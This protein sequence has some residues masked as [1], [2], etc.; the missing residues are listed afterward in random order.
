MPN[1][2]EKTHQVESWNADFDLLFASVSGMTLTIMMSQQMY[3]S[4]LKA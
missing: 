2:L 4:K 3:V 1:K